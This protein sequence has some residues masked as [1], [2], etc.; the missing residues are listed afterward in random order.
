MNNSGS[1]ARLYG[2]FDWNKDGDFLDASESVFVNVS[3]GTNQVV[4]LSVL[5]PLTA[6]RM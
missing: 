4:D 1:A 5:V 6:V 3:N 2:F